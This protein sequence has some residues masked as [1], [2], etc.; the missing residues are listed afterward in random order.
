MNNKFIHSIKIDW[1]KVEEDSYLKKI[2]SISEISQLSFTNNV[3]YFIGEN[4]TGKS[5]LLEA[6]AAAYGFNP[7][8]GTLNYRF[9]TYNDT[10]ELSNAISISKGFKRPVSSFFFRAES[11]FNVA[12]KAI[13]Y[14]SVYG[15]KGLHEQSHGESFLSFFQSFQNEGIYIM[16]EPE[17]ALSLQRQ[18]TLL[19]QIAEMAKKGS[20]FIIATHSPIIMAI[21]NSSIWSFDNGKIHECEYEDTENYQILKMFISNRESFINQLLAENK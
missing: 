1:S 17:S 12:T 5:T 15:E 2:D 8:G 20:Q 4:G 16:D 10:S 18:L 14:D 6:I 21:P 13:E 9:S 3:T 19:I 11:F 7:E